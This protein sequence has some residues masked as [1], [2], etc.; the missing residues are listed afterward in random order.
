M[1]LN[2]PEQ[3]AQKWAFLQKKCAEKCIFLQKNAVL[4]QKNELS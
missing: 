4:L 1:I 2:P 3:T